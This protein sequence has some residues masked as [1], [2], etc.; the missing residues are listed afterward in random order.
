M[1]HKSSTD[2]AEGNSLLRAW[3]LDKIVEQNCINGQSSG[4]KLS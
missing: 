2:L 3:V 1:V 4:M